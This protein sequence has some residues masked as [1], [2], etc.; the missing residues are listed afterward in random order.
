MA[1]LEKPAFDPKPT[2]IEE[3]IVDDIE[4]RHLESF[5][6][7]VERAY[8]GARDLVMARWL[9]QTITMVAPSEAQVAPAVTASGG[10]EWS[11][12]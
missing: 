11:N 2:N 3:S 1:E 8:A 6:A 5:T 7:V 4:A 9:K 12:S 10:E